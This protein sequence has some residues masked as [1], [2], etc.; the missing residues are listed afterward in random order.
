MQTS[1][2]NGKDLKQRT[3]VLLAREAD[4]QVA[5]GLRHIAMQGRLTVELE[6]DDEDASTAKDLL[7]TCF[8][9]QDLH[10]DHLVAAARRELPG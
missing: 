8:Q 4:T 3:G 10:E 2:R 5:Q 9:P 7:A 1:G 6:R